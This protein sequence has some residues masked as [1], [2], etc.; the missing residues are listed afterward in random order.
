MME[1]H[2]LAQLNIEKDIHNKLPDFNC[3]GYFFKYACVCCNGMCARKLDCRTAVYSCRSGTACFDC[4]SCG[5][6]STMVHCCDGYFLRSEFCCSELAQS[7][8]LR[9][10]VPGKK[11]TDVK[12]SADTGFGADS[13][14]TMPP[15]ETL[16]LKTAC[17]CCSQGCVCDR[18]CV[19]YVGRSEMLF[20][21]R[22]AWFGMCKPEWLCGSQQGMCLCCDVGKGQPWAPL[23][24]KCRGKTLFCIDTGVTS[25]VCDTS[26]PWSKTGIALFKCVSQCAFFDYRCSA[27]C[28]KNE[29]PMVIALL[30]IVC[31]PTF[32]CDCPCFKSSAEKFEAYGLAAP[33][34]VSVSMGAPPVQKMR[35]DYA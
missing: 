4:R 25:G 11:I 19:G 26:Y 14:G 3:C 28:D 24:F 17:C 8:L 2:W 22:Q 12:G 18:S 23:Q 20:T 15:Y 33:E 34:E 13:G 1:G 31:Y 6:G 16:C 7:C 32:H 5:R 21:S 27:C 29:M 9:L 35:D 10:P 30:G